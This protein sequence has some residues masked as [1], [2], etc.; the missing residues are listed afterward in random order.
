MDL[1]DQED[2]SQPN[3]IVGKG[4]SSYVKVTQSVVTEEQ[5]KPQVRNIVKTLPVSII[6]FMS[7]Y[8]KLREDIQQAISTAGES[9]DNRW[10]DFTDTKKDKKKL[11]K[12][13]RK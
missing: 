9:E 3:L 5:T 7:G 12:K 6:R 1:V 13:D 11:S 10:E 8:Q 4:I 2:E